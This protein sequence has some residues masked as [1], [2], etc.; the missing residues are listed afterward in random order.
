MTS[1]KREE[2]ADLQKGV[3]T[4]GGYRYTLL[5]DEKQSFKKAKVIIP[6]TLTSAIGKILLTSVYLYSLLLAPGIVGMQRFK[7]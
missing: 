3:S 4:S 2:E 1:A 6:P 5:G 7:Y